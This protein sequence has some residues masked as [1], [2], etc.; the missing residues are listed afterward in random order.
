MRKTRTRWTRAVPAAALVTAS[1]LS[2]A[3]PAHAVDTR[4]WAIDANTQVARDIQED[5][6]FSD[7]DE[8]YVAVIG[9]RTTPGVAGSTVAV[10]RGGLTEIDDIDK[11]ETHTIPDSMGRIEFPSVTRRSAAQVLAGQAPELIGTIH[12]VFESDATP[13]SSMSS[14]MNKLAGTVRTEIAR[15]IEPL[16]MQS[17]TDTTAVSKQLTAA[18]KRI[19]DSATPSVLEGLGLWLSSWS[20]PDDLIGAKVSLFAA[21]DD[22]LAPL[23]EGPVAGAI[24]SGTGT[25]GVVKTR[26]YTQTYSG[27]GLTYDIN[28]RL[29]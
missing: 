6:I 11:G 7:G 10:F 20:D 29:S 19:R 25:A 24:S 23:V 26:N 3:T 12:V 9:F 4:T 27:D 22:S 28:V 13:F 15:V 16:N 1:V 5:G 2:Q 14:Q 21:V 8:F 18:S 17:L